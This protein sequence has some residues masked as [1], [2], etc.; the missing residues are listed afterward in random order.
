MPVAAESENSMACLKHVK[1][2]IDGTF[3]ENSVKRWFALCRGAALALAALGCVLT[4]TPSLAAPQPP[5]PAAVELP[6]ASDVLRLVRETESNQNRDLT[7]KLRM[8][9][10]DGTLI[11]PFRLTMKGDVITYQFSNPPESLVLRLGEKNSRLERVTGSGKTQTIAGAKLDE[12][13][14][15]TDITYEDLALKFLYWNNATVTGEDN[16]GISRCWVV[17]AAPS[18][19]DDSQ[20]DRVRLW[21]EKSGGL[22]KAECYSRGK[23][24]R[25]FKVTNVQHAS[26]GGY[27]LKSMRVQKTGKEEPTYLEMNPG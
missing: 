14:R 16:L 23:L 9:T 20:Y 4:A 3:I 27:M 5:P 7:G 17:E 12:P 10:E 15:G 1:T 26:S 2:R 18:G 19:K 11:A 21:V 6:K 25:Q 22:L 13:V 8:S 24:V